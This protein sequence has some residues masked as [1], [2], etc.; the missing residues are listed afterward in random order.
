MLRNAAKTGPRKPTKKEVIDEGNAGGYTPGRQVYRGLR[1]DELE[2]HFEELQN[3]G[4]CFRRCMFFVIVATVFFLLWL[5]WDKE[6]M[7]AE[8]MQAKIQGSNEE[9]GEDLTDKYY[10][11]LNVKKED[12]A[13]RE[14]VEEAYKQKLEEVQGKDAKDCPECNNQLVQLQDAYN[15]LSTHVV[16][17]YH[18]VLNVNKRAG[19]HDIKKAYQKAKQE[20][21]EGKSSYELAEI[22]E[23]FDIMSHPEARIYYNLYA[24][25]PPAM[26]KHQQK[27]T[28]GGW[29]VEIG[30]GTFKYAILKAWLDYFDNG[31]VDIGFFMCI[32]LV[33]GIKVWNNRH[34][35]MEKIEQLE[36]MERMAMEGR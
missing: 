17:D 2:A 18:K 3:E 28:H 14:K 7:V 8:P 13:R 16:N 19:Y 11:M 29:G 15:A 1:Q 32:F 25:K 5:K 24:A 6:S 30:M 22:K 9:G 33:L 34:E 12:R 21:E 35:F 26:M 31:W 20:A 36:A 23:A 27:V 4:I 10:D